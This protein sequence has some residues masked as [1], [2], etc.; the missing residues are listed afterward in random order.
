MGLR[1][2]QLLGEGSG[3]PGALDVGK[4]ETAKEQ[5]VQVWREWA[6]PEL[7]LLVPQGVLSR[8]LGLLPVRLD[9]AGPLSPHAL[10]A[11]AGDRAPP[12]WGI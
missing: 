4:L 11:G 6:W 12:R 8:G 9:P 10:L 1:P 7:A 5:T 2:I 3:L